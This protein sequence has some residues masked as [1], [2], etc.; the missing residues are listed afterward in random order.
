MTRMVN[1]QGVAVKF[2]G[3]IQSL[4][5]VVGAALFFALVTPS[6]GQMTGEG[7]ISTQG[8]QFFQEDPEP[9][10]PQP[11][12]KQE[13]PVALPPVQAPERAPQPPPPVP[14]Q[15]RP[16]KF[17]SVVV[18]LD[19]S[20]SMLNRIPGGET[21]RLEEAKE[22]LIDVVSGMS[23]DTRVQ[24]WLF[25]TRL[26]PV[27]IRPGTARSFIPV[28]ER[29]SRQQ[30]IRQIKAIRTGG[31]TNLYRS[32]IQTL[33]IFSAPEDQAAYRS[34]ERFPVLVIISDGEDAMKTGHTLDA[35]LAARRRYPLVT[36]NAIG[37]HVSGEKSWTEKLCQIATTPEG[38][39][40][41]D[42]RNQLL[43]ILESFYKSRGN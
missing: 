24:M 42:D 1:L 19:A 36:I 26:V 32:I 22:A 9:P 12:P 4:G 13:T 37:F 16:N 5:F 8:T 28:G 2:I 40:T 14:R 39:A 7:V 20:D 29:G 33:K 3:S 38:C 34:G 31:G 21:T 25:N 6:L 35:V 17:P 43:K 23:N 27:A 10:P 11:K 18:L 41:A 30:L 15:V